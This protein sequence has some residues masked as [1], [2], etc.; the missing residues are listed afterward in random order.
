MGSEGAITVKGEPE[1]MEGTVTTVTEQS[2]DTG[3]EEPVKRQRKRRRK[4]P[5]AAEQ[6]E[7]TAL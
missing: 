3:F 7:V 5:P 4:S 2:K 1:V 6:A